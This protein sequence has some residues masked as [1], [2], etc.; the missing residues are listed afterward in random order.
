MFF[1]DKK[2]YIYVNEFKGGF[3]MVIHK[4]LMD[5]LGYA[6]TFGDI[7]IMPIS[8]DAD[9]T[10]CEVVFKTIN[11]MDFERTIYRKGK[12]NNFVFSTSI[13]NNPF[14][15]DLKTGVLKKVHIRNKNN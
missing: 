11:K 14:T 7:D 15:V 3:N 1:L 2:I 5:L 9:D 6:I 12:P 10:M 4:D 8:I 13:N